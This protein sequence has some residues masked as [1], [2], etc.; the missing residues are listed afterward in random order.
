MKEIAFNKLQG[1]PK[2]VDTG[3][4]DSTKT[5]GKFNETHRFI[6]LERLGVNISD[7]FDY[8]HSFFKQIDVLKLGIVLFR[9]IERL[10]DL[11]YLHLDIKPDNIMVNNRFDDIKYRNSTRTPG[12]F[13]CKEKLAYNDRKFRFSSQKKYND[14]VESQVNIIDF[15]QCESYIDRTTNQHRP[16][17]R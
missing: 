2:L 17:I 9:N 13:A 6:V 15:G 12:L 10:H 4:A 16:N 5:Y 11:G 3:Y 8:N 7:I 1:F 14:L